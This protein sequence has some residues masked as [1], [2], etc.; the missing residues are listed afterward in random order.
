MGNTMLL[1]R[2]FQRG[3][4]LT[5]KNPVYREWI[6]RF[7]VDEIQADVGIKGDITSRA[8]LPKKS[9]MKAIIMTRQSGILAGLE[10]ACFLFRKNGLKPIPK[11]K[12]GQRIRK[13]EI[14]LEIYGDTRELLRVER[15]AVDL[16]QRMS[17]IATLTAKLRTHIRNRVP[18]APTRK[19]Q[20]RYLDKKA[21][22]LG[23]G[24]THRLALWESILIKDNHLAALKKQGVTDP[25]ALSLQRAW[26][27]S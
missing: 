2:A 9:S 27:N 24:M 25:I 23:G 5:L 20:W 14:V 8:V 12:D 19:T 7:I 21:V 16:L 22:F 10:E 6:E 4:E 17:G 13:G 3:S 18:I 26:K 15:S 11:K 1:E